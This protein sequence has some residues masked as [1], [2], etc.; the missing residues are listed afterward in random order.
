MPP[1]RPVADHGQRWAAARRRHDRGLQLLGRARC[2]S[3][4]HAPAPPTPR[5]AVP[6]AAA[7]SRAGSSQ[8]T[9]GDH[10]VPARPCLAR[11]TGRRL[12]SSASSITTPSSSAPKTAAP[13]GATPADG[14]YAS[15]P[16]AP[17]RARLQGADAQRGADRDGPGHRPG[18]AGPRCAAAGTGTPRPGS[19]T[20][21][22]AW[23]SRACWPMPPRRTGARARPRRG[24]GAGLPRRL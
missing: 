16:G 2:S 20:S 9:R 12:S 5:C 23:C 21:T 3:R 4:R 13:Q 6:A 24:R 10:R 17:P 8:H 1:R 7:Q 14:R 19:I 18:L 22:S 15:P 11:R